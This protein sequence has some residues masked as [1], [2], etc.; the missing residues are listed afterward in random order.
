VTVAWLLVAE[1]G[2]VVL[3]GPAAVGKS[4]IGPLLAASVGLPF[5]DLDEVAGGYY[6]EAGM[7]LTDFRTKI[8]A[9]GYAAAHRWWQPARVNALQRVLDDCPGSVVAVGAGHTHFEDRQFADAAGSALRRHVVVLLLPERDRARS[10][11]LLRERSVASKRHDWRVGDIDYLDVWLR[12][13]QNR[14]L[15]DHVVYLCGR[16]PIAVATHVAGVLE[17]TP[18]AEGP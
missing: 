3:I 14:R 6:S 4:T 16:T 9:V 7:S 12:S 10:V 1:A 8:D 2:C 11:A 18:G 17:R 15:S 13:D 5:V